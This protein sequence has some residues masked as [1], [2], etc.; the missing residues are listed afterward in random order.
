M[1]ASIVRSPKFLCVCNSI[2]SIEQEWLYPTVIAAGIVQHVPFIVR[3]LR[4]SLYSEHLKKK[5]RKNKKKKKRKMMKNK[6]TKKRKNS[7]N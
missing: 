5:L 2:T 6:E 3:F 1:E 7:R 4:V